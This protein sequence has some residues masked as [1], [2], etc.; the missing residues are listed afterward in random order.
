MMR[1]RPTRLNSAVYHR[2]FRLVYDWIDNI[3]SNHSVSDWYHDWIDNTVFAET[4][5][6]VAWRMV[7][8]MNDAMRRV[9]L[10]TTERI[11]RPIEDML[12]RWASVARARIAYRPG[13]PG[14]LVARRRFMVNAGQS[15]R[16]RRSVPY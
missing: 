6:D 4:D 9:F 10:R 14:Y 3:V 7:D 13:G 2:L 8:S 15:R 1:R 12:R 5:H 16:T 11:V